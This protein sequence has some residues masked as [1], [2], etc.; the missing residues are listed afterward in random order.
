MEYNHK[1]TLDLIAKA[2]KEMERQRGTHYDTLSPP[3]IDVNVYF[4][5]RKQAHRLEKETTALK[6]EKKSPG[7]EKEKVMK[8]IEAQRNLLC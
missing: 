2:K 8:A 3:S 4:T 1:A 6:L 7:K 5:E